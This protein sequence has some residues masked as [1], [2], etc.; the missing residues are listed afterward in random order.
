[1]TLKLKLIAGL[2]FSV[3]L[4]AGTLYL[5]NVFTERAEYKAQVESLE[6]EL[7]ANADMHEAIVADLVEKNKTDTVVQ[8]HETKIDAIV[9]S[10]KESAAAPV[11]PVIRDALRGL[12]DF[13]TEYDNSTR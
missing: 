9:A 12:R 7:A 4:I 10:H 11:S 5:R 8:K 2:L 1:M 3:A 6:A 13:Q